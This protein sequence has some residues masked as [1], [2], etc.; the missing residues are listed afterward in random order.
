M[1]FFAACLL[2]ALCNSAFA[3]TPFSLEGLEGVNITVLNKKHKVLDDA[4][5]KSLEADIASKLK[6]VGIK[7]SSPTFSNF[8]IKVQENQTEKNTLC[9]VTLSLIENVHISRKNTVEAIAI[10]F[11]KEDSFESNDL[12]ADIRESVGFLVDEFIDQYKEE[13]P[14]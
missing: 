13:N 1:R 9:R 14:K 5:K 7:T 11:S 8:L 2:C 3:L 6:A 12:E 4:F 10:T